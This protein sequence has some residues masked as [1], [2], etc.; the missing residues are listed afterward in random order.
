MLRKV[1]RSNM[2]LLN[3]IILT[4]QNDNN[5]AIRAS[6]YLISVLWFLDEYL[7]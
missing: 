6:E 4:F 2:F 7:F 3:C 1:L 5:Y